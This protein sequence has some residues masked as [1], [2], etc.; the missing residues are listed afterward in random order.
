MLKVKLPDC[1]AVTLIGFA[2]LLTVN[3]YETSVVIPQG[4]TLALIVDEP[5]PAMVTDPLELTV[6]TFVFVELYVTL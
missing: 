6:A 4:V 5:A 1:E 3:E 2:A